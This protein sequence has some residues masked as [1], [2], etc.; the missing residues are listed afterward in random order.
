MGWEE[1]NLVLVP[2][3]HFHTAGRAL[4]RKATSRDAISSYRPLIEVNNRQFLKNAL[5]MVGDPSS[6]INQ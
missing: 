4:L 5:G 2:P 3:G 1:W 6:L